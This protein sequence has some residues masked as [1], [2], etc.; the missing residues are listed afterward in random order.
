MKRDGVEDSFEKASTYL[1]S[2][3]GNQSDAP[4]ASRE[5]RLMYLTEAPAHGGLSRQPGREA[6]QGPGM[7]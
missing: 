7:A 6:H 2:V 3:S 5:R 1:D 4:G